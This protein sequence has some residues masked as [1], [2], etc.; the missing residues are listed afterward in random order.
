MEQA[1]LSLPTTASDE[2]LPG[3]PLALHFYWNYIVRE[4][5]GHLFMMQ[6]RKNGLA[7]SETHLKNGR[8]R[9]VQTW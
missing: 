9:R 7:A 8:I 5:A 6:H 1:R 3:K 4:K 2:F